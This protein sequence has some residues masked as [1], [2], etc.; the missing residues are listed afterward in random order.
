M[1]GR[2]HENTTDEISLG[3]ILQVLTMKNELVIVFANWFQIALNFPIL[4]QYFAPSCGFDKTILEGVTQQPISR[5]Q[6]LKSI[7]LGD[8]CCEFALYL[9]EDWQDKR[10]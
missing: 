3:L 2:L 9:P 7:L 10:N 5:D 8:D 6:V 1:N 4:I